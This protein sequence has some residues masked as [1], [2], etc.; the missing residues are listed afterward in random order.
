MMFWSFSLALVKKKRKKGDTS[1]LP[2]CKKAIILVSNLKNCTFYFDL[3]PFSR[4]FG[5]F[6][7]VTINFR[8]KLLLL[9]LTETIVT[10]LIQYQMEFFFHKA[11]FVNAFFNFWL[12]WALVRSLLGRSYCCNC[13]ILKLFTHYLVLRL[14]L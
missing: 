8:N 2:G 6:F 11:V 3:T 5:H 4:D 12:L 10:I 7:K 9:R 1:V 13:D 14:E